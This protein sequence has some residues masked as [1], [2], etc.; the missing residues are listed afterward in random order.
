[1]FRFLPFFLLL[2][3]VRLFAFPE[4][5]RSYTAP[6]IDISE[7]GIKQKAYKIPLKIWFDKIICQ[8]CKKLL[9]NE[10]EV[11]LWDIISNH[12][13]GIRKVQCMCSNQDLPGVL[14]V[15]HL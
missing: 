9:S 8:K 10:K 14:L 1:M 4:L 12:Q 11:L 2:P 7:Y 3:P 6:N 5:P 13:C 15:R